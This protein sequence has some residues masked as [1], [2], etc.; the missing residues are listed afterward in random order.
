M[1]LFIFSQSLLDS[2]DS[3]ELSGGITNNIYIFLNN[4]NI[5]ININNLHNL[6]RK[7]AHFSEFFL[8]G[9]FWGIYYHL[10]K[11]IKTPNIFT[12]IQG[13]I[14]A[15]LD[16]FIQKFIPG[17]SGQLTDVLIDTSGVIFAVLI[18]YII[19]KINKRKD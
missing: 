10:E 12:I 13:I 2:V 1:T 17:R 11:A 9:L 5:N 7:L 14:T 8:L 3:S 16:E 15:S 18:I 6:I 19:K 4:L